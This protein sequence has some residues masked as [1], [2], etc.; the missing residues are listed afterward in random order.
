MAQ[1][2]D[3]IY[4]HA[5]GKPTSGKVVCHGKH[6]ATVKDAAGQHH[7]VKWEGVL[8]HKTRIT[9]AMNVID[10][11]VDGAIVEDENG[12]RG[13]VH[14]YSQDEPAAP[15][16]KQDKGFEMLG[17]ALVL[18]AKAGPIKGKAGLHLED[19][20]DKTGRHAKHWVK[21]Q[22]AAPAPRET[23]QPESASAPRER[24]QPEDP[25]GSKHGYGTHN[26]E[27][28]DRVN[29]EIDGKQMDGEITDTG[30]DGAKVKT[31]EG[32]HKVYWHE[33]KGHTPKPGTEKPKIDSSVLGPRDPVEAVSFAAGDW[34][35]AH[36][37]GSV[38]PE[39]V[40]KSFPPETADKIAQTK[41]RLASIEQTITNHRL[42]GEGAD[43]VY[44]DDRLA[45]HK[46]IISH[47]FGEGRADA[48]RPAEGT[49]PTFT[50][51]G[52]RGGSGKSWF[53]SRV[54]D[55]DKCIVLDAD[56]IKGMLPE[57][58][59]WNAAEV[60][61]ESSDILEKMLAKCREQGLNVVLD[62]T[63]KTA[64]SAVAKAN[65]FKGAGYRF[66]AH[67]MHLPRQEAA[68]RA[69][70]RFLG[71]TQRFVPPE[72]V[73]SNTGNEASFDQVK[74]LAD[75]WS[76]RDNNVKEG[77][78][79][80]LISRH[81]EDGKDVRGHFKED[82]DL[83]APPKKG[84][85]FLV[86]RAGH[87]DERSLSNRNAGDALAVSGHIGNSEDGEKPHMPGDEPT[88]VHAFRVSH[89]HDDFDEFARIQRGAEEKEGKSGGKIGRGKF[90]GAVG[91]SFP[92]DGYDEEY[93]GS[94]PIDDMRKQMQSKHGSH[95]RAGF[96]YHGAYAGA[97]AIRGAKYEHIGNAPMQ[98]SHAP[99][100]LFLKGVAT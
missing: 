65:V 24:A 15:E 36:D 17:K 92:S 99:V 81:G 80:I 91:H 12:R 33:V 56:E 19:R 44:D 39:S 70:Q 55:P 78:P 40:L 2:G 49:P 51:L 6:G 96:D 9:P 10:Q 94:A 59:G 53:K 46:K 29:F 97:D 30:K 34:A 7:K 52:G 79:P 27:A 26:L 74:G 50:M 31:E 54:Y 64:K 43:A 72:V 95:K 100:I 93:L 73:L 16:P 4:F 86:Y 1:V 58:E 20:T 61:E 87:K 3:E 67:Y 21:G 66:E 14:G 38:S 69:V 90:E 22:E 85:S 32:E 83:A 28:G 84:Q 68:K 11:G 75:S 63:M 77:D 71:K 41:E 45:I 35:K 8:G 98:K 48:A 88:H 82:S 76:F 37:D 57:Y 18:F 89:K 25:R 62:A 5:G 13:Y 42:S 23:A 47:F 60:H